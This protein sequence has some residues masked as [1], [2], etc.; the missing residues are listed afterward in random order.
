MGCGSSRF[1]KRNEN[2]GDFNTVALQFVGGESHSFDGFPF[3]RVMWAFDKAKEAELADLLKVVGELKSTDETQAKA[4]YACTFLHATANLKSLEEKY[5]KLAADAKPEI[6]NGKYTH[7]EAIRQ[8][9]DV[10]EHLKKSGI[11]VTE[12]KKEEAKGEEKKE[13]PKAE[14]EVM[15][16]GGDEAA[17]DV[18][19]D[20]GMGMESSSPFKYD[21]DS[22]GYDGWEN[23]PAILLRNLI[24]NPYWGDQVKAEAIAWEFNTEKGKFPKANLIP[25]VPLN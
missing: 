21:G 12:E 23:L 15:M 6:L 24:V 5:G 3:D 9:K 20:A 17:A 19:P 2:A 8:M 4:V 14:G 1:D 11:V 25:F 10:I 7:T 16:E 18:N 22:H 13:E